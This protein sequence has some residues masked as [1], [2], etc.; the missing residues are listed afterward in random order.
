MNKRI[1][2]LCGMLSCATYAAP[3]W[4]QVE[5]VNPAGEM[6]LQKVSPAVKRFTIKLEGSVREQSALNDIERIIRDIFNNSRIGTVAVLVSGE[7]VASDVKVYE[8]LEIVVNAKTAE[9]DG[10]PYRVNITLQE[11]GTASGEPKRFDYLPVQAEMFSQELTAYL[12]KEL[13]LQPKP[14]AVVAPVPVVTPSVDTSSTM[15]TM[16]AMTQ[17]APAVTTPPVVVTTPKMVATPNDGPKYVNPADEIQLQNITPT[18]KRFAIKLEGSVREQSALTDIER[19]IRQIF[20]ESRIGSVTVPVSGS[21]VAMENKVYENLEIVV[22]A[23]TAEEADKPY[24]VN[25]TL[26]EAGSTGGAPVPFSYAPAYPDVFY[27]GLKAH[28][29]KELNLQPK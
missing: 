12:S 11:R 24:A 7:P 17:T 10:Q 4:A 27:Q 29:S 23:K 1:A 14:K 28:L 19:M 26:R 9:E 2:V 16:P 18:V 22:N 8:N 5:N 20:R 25:L 6:Q 15:A 3:L 21:P 13:N